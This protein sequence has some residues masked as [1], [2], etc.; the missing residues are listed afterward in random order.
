MVDQ[1]LAADHP[2]EVDDGVGD[3]ARSQNELVP[4]SVQ[5]DGEAGAVG[6]EVGAAEGASLI[7]VRSAW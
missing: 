7:A 5:G 1:D 4:G 2:D 3:H 6:I